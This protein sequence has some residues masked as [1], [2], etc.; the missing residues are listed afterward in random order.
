MTRT[1]TLQEMVEQAVGS[2]GFELVELERSAGG[3]LRVTIDFPWTADDGSA[4]RA[5]GVDECE[6]VSRQLQYALE[7]ENVDYQRLE[8]SS[9]GIDRPLRTRQDFERFEGERV[10]VVLKE[11]IAGGDGSPDVMHIG[12]KRFSGRLQRAGASSDDWLLIWR[13]D[14]RGQKKGGR[15]GAASE[16]GQPPVDQE[17][18]LSFGLDDLQSARLQPVLDFRH[19]QS[20]RGRRKRA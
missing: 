19:S 20:G 12:R 9:P 16:P 11:P 5:I 1:V 2:L 3:L 15:R 10:A 14:P 13:D 4:P 18:V 7:V 6:T 8:V 17:Q